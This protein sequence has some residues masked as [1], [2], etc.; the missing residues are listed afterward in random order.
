M[1]IETI[2]KGDT[3]TSLKRSSLPLKINANTKL[4]EKSITH[5]VVIYKNLVKNLVMIF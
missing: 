5:I 1:L 2:V 4:Y 3:K